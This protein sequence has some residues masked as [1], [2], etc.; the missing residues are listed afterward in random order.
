MAMASDSN[1]STSARTTA[2]TSRFSV[3]ELTTGTLRC[4]LASITGSVSSSN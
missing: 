3:R 1:P 4:S 2:P